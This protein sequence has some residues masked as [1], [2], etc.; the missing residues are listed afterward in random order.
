MAASADGGGGAD[1]VEDLY[2]KYFSD[3]ITA[4]Y[5]QHNP[6]KLDDVPKLLV[7]HGARLPQLLE[8]IEKKYG[9]ASDEEGG[10]G[11]LAV[12]RA[13]AAA[14]VGAA[15]VA[16]AAEEA[17][18]LPSIAEITVVR[19]DDDDL[20]IPQE[21]EICPLTGMP[22]QFCP[23]G[24]YTDAE[25]A[26]GGCI[27][28][29]GG[30][31][32]AAGAGGGGDAKLSKRKQKEKEKKKGKKAEVTGG[33]VVMEKVTRSRRKCWTVVTGVENYGIKLKDVSKAISKKFATSSS[34]SKTASGGQE[35]AVQGD[36][37]AQLPPLLR[38]EFGVPSDKIFFADGKT[39]ISWINIST[40]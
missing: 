9:A 22:A 17:A 31:S 34:V 28:V 19:Q 32:E 15:E 24:P 16:A 37:T 25:R 8:A 30:G 18:P 6:S 36:I 23:Y 33:D 40:G 2:L 21:V 4:I 20:L 29:I 7:K 1:A 12:A 26:A 38:D 13:A 5:K 27:G 11:A 35:I 39:R 14:K 3:Q 10:G